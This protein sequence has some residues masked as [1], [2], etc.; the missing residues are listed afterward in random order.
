MRHF[1]LLILPLFLITGCSFSDSES[2]KP[3]KVSN[4]SNVTILNSETFF[5][6]Q[7]I[8]KGWV[9]EGLNSEDAF[10]SRKQAP[11]VENIKVSN[12]IG[13]HIQNAH[14][15]FLLAKYNRTS[16][17]VNP[18]L[19]WMWNVSEHTGM[20]HPVRL[21]IGFYGGKHDSQPLYSDD[22]IWQEGK[23]L[24]PFDRV[25]AIGYED[26]ALRRG[27]LYDFGKLKYFAQRGG[28]EQ[29]NQ[30]IEETVDLSI[31]YKA[32][33]PDD[34]FSKVITTFVAMMASHR[35]GDGAITFANI[36]L[37]K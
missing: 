25:L 4:L 23:R 27:N 8:P 3:L 20:H 32:A 10:F 2:T 12:I 13:T 35:E 19:S 37:N 7:N 33:W 14:R 11:K 16:L 18:Y 5:N 24:P 34:D 28:V 6:D 17:L 26:L 36:Q 22:L 21:M 30:W 9:L 29:T 31:I 15:D 1:A